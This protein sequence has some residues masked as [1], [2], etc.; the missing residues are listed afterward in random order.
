VQ[1]GEQEEP[2]PEEEPTY[3]QDP[4]GGDALSR[5]DETALG[6]IANDLGIQYLHRTA[7]APVDPAV[8]G[9][10]VGELVSE[11]GEPDTITE[12]Y[13]VFAI[14][15]GLLALLEIV[16]ISGAVAEVRPRARSAR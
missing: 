10:D 11:P 15:L 12:L 3:I 7:D 8:E 16:N 6:V 13:W 14:P 9:I 1:F 5:I 2:E 4:A